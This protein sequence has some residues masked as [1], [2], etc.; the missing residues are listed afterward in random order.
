MTIQQLLDALRSEVCR[1]MA[2]GEFTERSLAG[3]V[4]VS[5]PQIHNVLK[6]ARK[7]TPELA[8]RILQALGIS[9]LD[10]F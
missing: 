6:G 7:L 3:R 5:Q 9:V 1:R 8:D 2:N 4:G 10:L